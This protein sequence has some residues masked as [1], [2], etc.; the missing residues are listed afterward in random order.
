MAEKNPF[1]QMSMEIKRAIDHD[2]PIICGNEAVK[3]F[4]QNFQ[5]ESFFGKPWKN[6]KRRTGYTARY[7]TKSG[8]R[9]R[10]VPPAKG[11]AGSRRILTGATGDLGRSIKTRPGRASFTVYS[12]VPYSAVHNE[13]R[14]AGRGAGFTMPKRQFIG[15]SPE[16]HRAIKAKIIKHLNKIIK[17]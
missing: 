16:L 1:A 14:R 9:T 10:Q 6:V 2:L 5:K 11:A 8:W 7:K 3:L 15:E 17:P 4:K 13:G 12:D